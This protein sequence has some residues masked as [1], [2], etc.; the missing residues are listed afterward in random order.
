MKSRILFLFL[1]A[2][3]AAAFS[4][5]GGLRDAPESTAPAAVEATESEKAADPAAENPEDTIMIL[6]VNGTALTA[7][8]EENSSVSA[9]LELLAD[10]PLTIK[11]QDY[12][13]ME[14]VGS[15]GTD[16]PRNDRQTS[17]EAGD[18]ILYQGNSFV[19]YYDTNSWS[20]TRLGKIQGITAGALRELLGDG[21]VTVT[22]SL[23][24]QS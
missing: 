1:A 7:V 2:F 20:F 14:K 3:L 6:T 5:C 21:D 17:T 22:L 8:M 15:L 19:I 10:G 24:G 13:D 12:G 23:P 9:L 16:L 4:G 18:L 11:M